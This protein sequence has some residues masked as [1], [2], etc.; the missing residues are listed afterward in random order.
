[1]RAIVKIESW[2]ARV[3][4]YICI[5]ASIQGTFVDCKELSSPVRG[6]Q[7]TFFVGSSNKTSA[8]NCNFSKAYSSRNLAHNIVFSCFNSSS[9][10]K[11][12]SNPNLQNYHPRFNMNAI[13]EFPRNAPSP[14]FPNP[15]A[16]GTRSF[17]ATWE[18]PALS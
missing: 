17:S 18:L 7:R 8:L 12:R 10:N 5:L 15:S 14:T 9:I 1:M 11:L 13:L 2:I 6:L 3:L 16:L 4:V